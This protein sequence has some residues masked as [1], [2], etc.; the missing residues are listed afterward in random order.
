MSLT[1]FPFSPPSLSSL[2]L[3]LTLCEAENWL[4]T[5]NSGDWTLSRW[6]KVETKA[7]FTLPFRGGYLRPMF[8]RPRR[9]RGT[10]LVRPLNQRRATLNSICP[11]PGDSKVDWQWLWLD[12]EQKTS[13]C[14]NEE[15]V[16]AT[17]S[18]TDQ[19]FGEVPPGKQHPSIGWEPGLWNDTLELLYAHAAWHSVNKQGHRDGQP[20]L[21]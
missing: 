19:V 16:T 5:Q 14:L 7:P 12:M 10:S 6:D 4:W 17:D 13:S 15:K 20:S 21:R 18:P 9:N 1:I 8:R 3:S 11:W 2:L